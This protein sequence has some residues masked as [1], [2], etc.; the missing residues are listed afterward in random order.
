[1]LQLFL[2]LALKLQLRNMSCVVALTFLQPFNYSVLLNLQDDVTSTPPTDGKFP[3]NEQVTFKQGTEVT[4]IRVTVVKKT[5]EPNMNVTLEVFA[6][7]KPGK[8]IQFLILHDMITDFGD[9]PSNTLKSC[10]SRKK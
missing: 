9:I 2:T 7:F 3:A 4:K 1:M 6:C 10:Q 8:N 5:D